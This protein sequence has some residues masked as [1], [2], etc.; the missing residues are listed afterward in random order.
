MRV[1]AR[2]T[3]VAGILSMSAVLLSAPAPDRLAWLGAPTHV[4]PGVDL[5]RT[6]DASLVDTAGPIAVSLLRLDP[7]RVRLSTALAHPGEIDTLDSLDRIASAAGAIAAVNGGL[8]NAG[9]H[10]PVGV[11]KVDGELV[12]DASTLE[13]IAAIRSPARGSTSLEFD[14][15]SVAETASFDAAGRAHL[16]TIDGI[17]TTRARG[18]LM[19]YTPMYH[20]DTDTASTGTEWPLE[21]S[22]LRVSRV[23]VKQGRTPI[24]R[25]G[26]V[27]SYGG[28]DLPADLA[29]LAVGT[30][31]TIRAHWTTTFGMSASHLDRADSIVGG[32]GLLRVNG[33]SLADWP[34]TQNLG[35]QVFVNARHPR[36]LIGA[37]AHGGLWLAAVDGRD[38]SHS[39]GMTFADLERLCD[40]LDLTG[41]LNLDG[42]SSTG[43]VVEGTIVNRPAGG[44]P[45]VNNAILVLPRSGR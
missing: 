9:N 36:T 2:V 38:S 31:V 44:V 24:P 35:G 1:R 26:L 25:A 39:V 4:A 43:M 14:E 28:T 10:E 20:A 22:P 37:D 7:S 17:D 16:V 18:H 34:A 6:T 15:V 23:R 45:Q 41:A 3:P 13:G 40:R 27:L 33:R 29:A 30:R 19:L 42:G 21:G 32:A 5:Y 11:L 8:F 12:S